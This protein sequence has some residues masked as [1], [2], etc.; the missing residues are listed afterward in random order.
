MEKRSESRGSEIS[1]LKKERNPM[2][3]RFWPRLSEIWKWLVRP[4]DC[5]DI[6]L[7]GLCLFVMGCCVLLLIRR[8]L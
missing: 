8:N 5:N 2:E 7:F 3:K 6:F 1:S 4:F